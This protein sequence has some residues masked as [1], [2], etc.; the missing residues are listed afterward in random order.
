M[1]ANLD[2]EP[3][4][5]HFLVSL[6]KRKSIKPNYQNKLQ[7]CTQQ[8]IHVKWTTVTQNDDFFVQYYWLFTGFFHW[9]PSYLLYICKLKQI[10]LRTLCKFSLFNFLACHGEQQQMVTYKVQRYGRIYFSL[11]IRYATAFLIYQNVDPIVM[12]HNAP[13]FLWALYY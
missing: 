8:R 11:S 7:T 13:R 4:N 10:I 2:F 9:N 12:S 1:A 6:Q 5:V 3:F